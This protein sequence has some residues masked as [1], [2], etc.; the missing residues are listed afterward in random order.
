MNAIITGGAGDIGRACA[1]SSP[2]AE[3][4]PVVDTEFEAAE[5]VAREINQGADGKG[6]AI[7][8]DVSIAADVR[9]DVAR[10]ADWGPVDGIAHAAGIAGPAAPLPDFDETQFDRVMAVNARGTFL[11][12]K[13]A[14]PYLR[15]G[16]AIVNIASVTGIAGYP[17][18]PRTWHPNTPV[19]GLT[20]AA[21]LKAHRGA[22]ASTRSAPDR[23]KA[24]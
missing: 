6:I 21:A 8:A 22:S 10:A 13:Y 7:S 16:G 3:A 5:R 20:R 18:S 19:I 12:M 2:P 9:R 14:L 24:A 11:G 4:R 23:L 17:R 1:A 15:D